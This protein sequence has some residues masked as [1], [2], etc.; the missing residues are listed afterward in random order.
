MD[1]WG[2]LVHPDDRAAVFEWAQAHVAGETPSYE[3]E[4]RM[5]HRDGSVRWFLVRAFVTRDATGTAVSMAGTDTDITARKRGEE[6]LR[7]AEEI[8]RRIAE[9]T[10]DCVKILDLDGRLVYM[11][12]KGLR[13]LDLE[14]D[15]ALLE[16]PA[17]R[18]LRRGHARGG[19]RRPSTRRAAAGAAVSRR[20]LPHARQGARS[21]GTSP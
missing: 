15:G 4:H 20:L 17:G 8:N 16:P 3:L 10:G 21:G 7:Q 18:V 1:D 5:L 19:G 13:Q 12:P 2:R 11:N 14:D 6:A 9:S